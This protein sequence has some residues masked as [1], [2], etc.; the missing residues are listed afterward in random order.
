M[1]WDY[2]LNNWDTLIYVLVFV[3]IYIVL[4]LLW[5]KIASLETSVHRLDKIIATLCSKQMKP[6]EDLAQAQQAFNE[7]FVTAC[8]FRSAPLPDPVPVPVPV[9]V[10]Y[11]EEEQRI[12][13][14]ADETPEDIV[15]AT[16][17]GP[18]VHQEEH[19]DD[20][21][22]SKA[23]MSKKKL[24]RMNVDALRDQARQQNLSTDGTKAELIARI[25]DSMTK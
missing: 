21:T 14:I 9:S 4:I 13:E 12:T 19:V 22:D 5:R 6:T 3:I 2:L 10:P 11:I 8:N 20:E 1:I 18:M 23:S 25:V 15:K 24:Q 7:V 17:E 16:I